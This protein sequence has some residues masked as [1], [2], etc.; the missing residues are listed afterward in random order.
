MKQH[1]TAAP[2]TRVERRAPSTHA[3]PRIPGP[4]E[5]SYALGRFPF[6]LACPEPEEPE[7]EE[8]EEPAPEE[9]EEDDPE[10]AEA[11]AAGRPA[12]LALSSGGG[13]EAEAGSGATSIPIR[14]MLW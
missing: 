2:A 10:G 1:A 4:L 7:P 5:R 11:A 8:P 14:R 9:P 13:A 6:E 12:L 3:R